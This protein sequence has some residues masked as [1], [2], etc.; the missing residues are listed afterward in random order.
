METSILGAEIIMD[1]LFVIKD[2]KIL[3]KSLVESRRLAWPPPA[4][5]QPPPIDS[6]K[7]FDS[8]SLTSYIEPH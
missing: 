8:N 6:W 3:P 5:T 1:L 2:S 4:A 7:A